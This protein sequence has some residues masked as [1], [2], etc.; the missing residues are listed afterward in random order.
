MN[1]QTVIPI[2]IEVFIFQMQFNLKTIFSS[3]AWA[4][5]S[6]NEPK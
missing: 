3:Y 4:Q 5:M 6:S 1:Y 2:F